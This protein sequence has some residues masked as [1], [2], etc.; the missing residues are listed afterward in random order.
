VF[1]DCFVKETHILA[2]NLNILAAED[3]SFQF[4]FRIRGMIY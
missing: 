2:V 3:G 1:A 4:M